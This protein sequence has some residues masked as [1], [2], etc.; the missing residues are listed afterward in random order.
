MALINKVI[1]QAGFEIVRDVIG[2]ILKDELENQKVLQPLRITEEINIYSN[3]IKPFAQSETFM[4]NVSCDSGNYTSRS[5]SG[6]HGGVNYNIDVFATG[7]ETDT[8]N[9]GL[10]SAKVRDKYNGLITYILGD[11][12]YKT[13]GLQPGL[14]MGTSIESFENFEVSNN[15]DASFTQMCRIVFNVRMSETQ[16]FWDGVDLSQVNTD[17]K[18][19]LTENGYKYTKEF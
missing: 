3:R 13:L 14:I 7:K 6:N 11:T 2:V 10:N 1:S 17:V 16:S 8:E 4:I 18:L 12:H 15:Q 9:G 5:Q 19:G